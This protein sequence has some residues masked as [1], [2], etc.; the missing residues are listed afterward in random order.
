[1]SLGN[2]WQHK[3]EFIC[4]EKEKQKTMCEPGFGKWCI[5]NKSISREMEVWVEQEG[6]MS[7]QEAQRDESWEFRCDKELMGAQN[8]FRRY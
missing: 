4:T 3:K 6:N 5:P 8:H 7:H 1:M 2:T